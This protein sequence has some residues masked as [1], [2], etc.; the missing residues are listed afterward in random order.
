MTLLSE[1]M[2]RRGLDSGLGVAVVRIKERS[3]STLIT[4]ERG[5]AQ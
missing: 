3:M 5:N 4:P 1:E 2:G